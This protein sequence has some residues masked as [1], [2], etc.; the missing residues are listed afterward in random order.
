[1]SSLLSSCA[2]LTPS[3]LRLLANIDLVLDLGMELAF[4]PDA[5]GVRPSEELVG[6][7]AVVHAEPVREL[8]LG[9]SHGGQRRD[10]GPHAHEP[11]EDPGQVARAHDLRR[12]A[13][14]CVRRPD[15][16]VVAHLRREEPSRERREELLQLD[17]LALR[18]GLRVA[19]GVD[20]GLVQISLVQIPRVAEEPEIDLALVVVHEQEADVR[21]VREGLGLRSSPVPR[22]RRCTNS[23]L[24]PSDTQTLVWS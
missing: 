14:R 22:Q 21:N 20:V 16:E 4:E 3:V 2:A 15:V 8:P 24:Q 5:G 11:V 19:E 18:N 1:M 17:V 7:Q 13:L 23:A 12:I 6:D 10:A 9:A